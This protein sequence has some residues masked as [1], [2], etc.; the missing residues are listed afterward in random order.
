LLHLRWSDVIAGGCRFP[1]FEPRSLQRS[2]SFS[3]IDVGL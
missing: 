2:M 3:R 1:E